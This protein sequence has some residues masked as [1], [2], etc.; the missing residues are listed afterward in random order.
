MQKY[1]NLV[2]F[3]NAEKRTFSCEFGFDTAENEPAKNLQFFAK[4]GADAE[5]LDVESAPLT[6]GQREDTTAG[7]TQ[8]A[9]QHAKKER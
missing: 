3:E 5:D 1:A 4:K 8:Q 9:M 2:D 7:R 6:P